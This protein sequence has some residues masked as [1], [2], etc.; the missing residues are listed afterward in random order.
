MDGEYIAAGHA[1]SKLN[2]PLSST[3]LRLWAETGRIR[4]IRP[5][6]KRLY[7]FGDIQREVGQAPIISNKE[8]GKT[9]G[10]ARVSSSHQEADLERQIEYIKTHYPQVTKVVKD[11]GSGLNY[12]RKGL[13][14]VLSEVE[15]GHVET[16]VVTYRD[17]VCR[18]GFEFV[19]RIF[20][21]AKAKIVVLCQDT[22]A[23]KGSEAEL[24]Q[25]LLDVCNFF[26][27]KRNGRKAARYRS[28]RNR[29]A[30]ENPSVIHDLATEE[31]TEE[32][33]CCE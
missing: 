30:S 26:V 21:K 16:V 2:V 18:F 1:I 13:N 15:S 33:V 5:G 7:H 31:D 14:T 20:T 10:Y 11:I 25:D 32:V 23:S 22:D 9:I 29:L 8:P 27:A 28:E 4:F 19:D 24:A 17:R 12:N 3:S 6:G